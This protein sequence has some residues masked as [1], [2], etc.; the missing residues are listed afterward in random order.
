MI[1]LSDGRL[2]IATLKEISIYNLVSLQADFI[3]KDAHK[4]TIYSLCQIQN[5]R[6]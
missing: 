4:D 6:L 1:L 2:V 5:E 3:I